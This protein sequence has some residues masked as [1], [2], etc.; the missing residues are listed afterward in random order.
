MNEH[1]SPVDRI[2]GVISAVLNDINAGAF[3]NGSWLKL[4][5]LESRYGC[6]RADARRALEKLAIKGVVQRIQN[7]GFYVTRIDDTRHKELVEVRVVL[8]TATLED[9]IRNASLPDIDELE[10][11]AQSFRALIQEGTVLEKYQANQAFHSYLTNLC[12]NKELV[13]LTLEYRGNARTT[14]IEQWPSL[15]RIERS[16]DEHFAMVEAIKNEDL[17]TLVE[18]T[19]NHIRQSTC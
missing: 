2:E 1:T 18:L 15:A 12:S 9:V 8:E 19:R 14:S 3:T 7:R 13:S 11:L 5:E 4:A 17:E 10:R 16:A 6:S